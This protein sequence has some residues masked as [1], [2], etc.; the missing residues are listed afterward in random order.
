[1]W[2]PCTSLFDPVNS[3]WLNHTSLKPVNM[4]RLIKENRR[5]YIFSHELVE[6]IGKINAHTMRDLKNI[7]EKYQLFVGSQ[8]WTLTR[9]LDIS[10]VKDTCI[11]NTNNSGGAKIITT[12]RLSKNLF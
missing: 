7:I 9:N 1:M 2:L 11:Y 10:T 6:L 5:P 12:Y 8:N 3:F 4:Q